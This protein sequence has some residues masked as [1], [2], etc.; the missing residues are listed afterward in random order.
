MYEVARAIAAQV[1]SMRSD[2]ATTI[3]AGVVSYNAVLEGGC[4]A[5][6][7]PA[8]RISANR[9]VIQCQIPGA[10]D[11]G[12]AHSTACSG[13]AVSAIPGNGAV[14]QRPCADGSIQRA[15]DTHRAGDAGAARRTG[16]VA[17]ESTVLSRHHRASVIDAAAKS[18]AGSRT[19]V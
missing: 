3:F 9:A 6:N 1:V 17:G 13:T 2:R 4:A 7:N 11:D 14:V 12:T 18:R 15:A 19:A 8:S 5:V 10:I 16:A